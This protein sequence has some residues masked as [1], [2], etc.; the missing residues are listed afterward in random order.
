M[1][2]AGVDQA[3]ATLRLLSVGCLRVVQ[4]RRVQLK[5]FFFNIQRLILLY[6]NPSI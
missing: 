5:V 6:T 2:R 3:T 1:H 4:E